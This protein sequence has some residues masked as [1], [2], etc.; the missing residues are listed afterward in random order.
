MVKRLNFLFLKCVEL[1]VQHGK[2]VDSR[3]VQEC[4]HSTAV[5]TT[6]R[7]KLIWMYDMEIVM[8]SGLKGPEM[9]SRRVWT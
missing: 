3:H 2:E 6:E 1:H 8:E 5:N 7:K 9:L 4:G